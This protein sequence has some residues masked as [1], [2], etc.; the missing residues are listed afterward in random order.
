M[1]AGNKSGDAATLK[2]NRA[3]GSSSHAIQF[4][5]PS[6]SQ[7]KIFVTVQRA[8]S[9]SCLEEF[10]AWATMTCEET[11]PVCS[12]ATFGKPFRDCSTQPAPSAIPLDAQII[13]TV[14]DPN[15]NPF[16]AYGA[17]QLLRHARVAAQD[18]RFS[19]EKKTS[20]VH[21]INERTNSFNCVVQC[22]LRIAIC[23]DLAHVINVDSVVPFAAVGFD[24]LSV[25][26]RLSEDG[27]G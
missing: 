21:A 2:S 5:T 23:S 16:S 9:N 10:A 25:H 4:H 1:Q 3:Q 11:G 17:L 19:R 7:P 12:A 27:S 15:L 6:R 18:H 22:M 20:S 26:D 8:R 13:C 24:A 14:G